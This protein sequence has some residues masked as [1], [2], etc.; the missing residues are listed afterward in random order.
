LNSGFAKSITGKNLE[1]NT[2]L[3]NGN[4]GF[5][6]MTHAVTYGL[7][8]NRKKQKAENKIPWGIAMILLKQRL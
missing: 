1:A 3:K 7:M 8:Q 4:T 5:F 2:W 6:V